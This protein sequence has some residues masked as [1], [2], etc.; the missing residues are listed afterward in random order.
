MSYYDIG[1]SFALKV[2]HCVYES[3]GK[4]I[5]DSSI[6]SEY[7]SSVPCTYKANALSEVLG[8]LEGIEVQLN[9]EIEAIKKELEERK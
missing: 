5:C 7:Y 3:K 9:A 6:G 4:F 2:D 8:Y 1:K